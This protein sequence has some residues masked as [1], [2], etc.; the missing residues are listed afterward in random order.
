MRIPKRFA[1][2]ASVL[3]AGSLALAA[4]GD[5]G[6]DD[7]DQTSAPSLEDCEN[8]PNECNSGERAD[9]GEIT[10]MINQGHDGVFNQLR[11]EGNSVYL[12]Q[13]LA[14]LQEGIGFFSPDGEWNWNLN[15]LEEPAEL[16]NED[17]MTVVYQIRD[18][19]VWS[20]GEP[21]DVDDAI[22]HWYHMSGKDEHCEGCNPAATT[23]HDAVESIEGS[24]GGKTVTV[25]Y[26]EG[27][28][29]PE[30]FSRTLFTF[31]AHIAEQE[32]GD[33]Q[34]D[35]A[36]M[37]ETSEYFLNTVPT[38]SSGPYVVD[39]WVPDDRQELVPNDNWYGETQPTLDRL[40]KVVI[41]DQGSW[42]PNVQNEEINGGSPSSFTPDGLE[43]MS[44]VPGVLT[45]TGSAGAVWEHVDVNMAA[46]DDVALRR[47]IFTA[48][49]TEDAR[50]RI[51]SP[52]QPPLRTN[53]IFASSSPHHEDHLS[54]TGYG[55]GDA[56]AARAIL[57]EA[58][59]TGAEEGGTLTDPEGEPV[60]DVRFGFLQGNE[61]RATF[62]ELSIEYLNQIGITVVPEP[63]PGDQLGTVLAE[64]DFDLVIF[65]WAGS[66]LFAG[67]SHQFYHSEGGGNYGGL[68]NEQVSQLAE[69][70][71]NQIDIEES[72]A[73]VNQLVPLVLEEA[74]SLPLWD[75]LNFMFVSD[76]YTNIRDN[77]NDTL[78]SL[79]NTEHWGQ[80]AS[81]AQ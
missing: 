61:N 67:A 79:Y 60:P 73:L 23:L 80:A 14:G 9:G 72:A 39:E 34:N 55:T 12:T 37:G 66:P 63:I 58:G 20:D 26:E 40:A 64:A 78:R 51:Y 7:G 30:Y 42:V 68:E 52:L 49:N 53:H 74:Y 25:T 16:T 6:S 46:L 11:P 76:Q 2:A 18:E 3:L 4:C 48:I 81:A 56:D 29:N 31:P 36:V 33:W 77:H 62:T 70:V 71:R 75:T 10:W 38:W 65:G 13:M 32:V 17:P 1:G 50:E 19:A 69:Q 43:R 54:A 21:I 24:D 44:N 35:P 41:S 27:Y 45:N 15:V 22:W 5:D 28:Q 57:E 8:N 47:A 59:Y